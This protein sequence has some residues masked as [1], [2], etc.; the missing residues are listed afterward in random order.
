MDTFRVNMITEI[1]PTP[2]STYNAIFRNYP[3]FK[4]FSHKGRRNFMFNFIQ[5]NCTKMNIF[6]VQS[7][8][9]LF[10]IVLQTM[11]HYHDIQFF[12]RDSVEHRS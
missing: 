12:E 6:D 4:D 2:E 11:T 3:L 7:R 9:Y 10:L 1:R 8:A 5:F